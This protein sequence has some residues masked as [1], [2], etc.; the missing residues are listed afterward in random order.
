MKHYLLASTEA[1]QAHTSWREHSV[2]KKNDERR[3]SEGLT[4]EDETNE[5]SCMIYGSRKRKCRFKYTNTTD[6]SHSQLM[7]RIQVFGSASISSTE[8]RAAERASLMG[9]SSRRTIRVRLISF[10]IVNA[11]KTRG[12]SR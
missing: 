4:A 12:M 3:L 10:Q 7:Y 6:Q 8:L 9:M 5:R 1:T 11:A 2:E